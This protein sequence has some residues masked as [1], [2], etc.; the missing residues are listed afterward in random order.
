MKLEV[1]YVNQ[2]IACHDGA[3][4]CPLTHEKK[5]AI[6]VRGGGVPCASFSFLISV[7]LRQEL[8]GIKQVVLTQA[9]KHVHVNMTYTRSCILTVKWSCVKKTFLFLKYL[10][11]GGGYRREEGRI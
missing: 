6:G 1:Q 5:N 8:Q 4:A 3:P 9:C 2:H 7:I 11:T 10:A